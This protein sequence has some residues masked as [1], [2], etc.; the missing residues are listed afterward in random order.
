VR[1]QAYAFL[2]I[3]YPENQIPMGIKYCD[4]LIP[5][6]SQNYFGTN[7]QSLLLLKVP[8]VLALYAK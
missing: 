8:T 3:H 1:I 6:D 7:W 4:A 2:L 5:F